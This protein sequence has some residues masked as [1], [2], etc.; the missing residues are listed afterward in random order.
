V[1]WAR[2]S[3]QR[4]GVSIAAWIIAVICFATSASAFG[5]PTP[6][7][8]QALKRSQ[9]VATSRPDTRAAELDQLRQTP[10]DPRLQA[11]AKQLDDPAFETREAATRQLKDDSVDLRQL[12]AL[13]ADGQLSCEQRYRLLAIVRDRLVNAPRGAVGIRMEGMFGAPGEIRVAELIPGLPA[14]KVLEIGDRITQVDGRD[15]IASTDLFNYVQAK[16]PGEKV[17]LTVKRTRVDDHGKTVL[18]D[19]NLPV[20]DT[21]QI[22]IALG[23]ADL[24]RP[25]PNMPMQPNP[26]EEARREQARQTADN[27]GPRARTVKI[28]GEDSLSFNS[29]N[30]VHS[31]ADNAKLDPAVEQ[32]WAIRQIQSERELIRQGALRETDELRMRW[33][34]QL[35]NLILMTQRQDRPLSERDFLQR[36]IERF[37]QLMNP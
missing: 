14:E 21:L 8:D 35:Q 15:L 28:E 24:L 16:N 27:F 5:Q 18:D 13:L 32:Y 29:P 4:N 34:Q 36:V 37:V 26:V 23:S 7:P 25:V 6:R 10:V 2:H 11:C 17:M 30:A 20:S 12:Y 31:V 3:N 9:P 1:D 19:R 22:E 33:Q